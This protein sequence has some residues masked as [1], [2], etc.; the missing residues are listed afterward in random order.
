MAL[1]PLLE[2][3]RPAR[4]LIDRAAAWLIANKVLLP[5]VT[6]IERLVGRIRDRARTRLWRHLV[7][8]LSDD[9]R[10]R[11][12]GLF[13]DGDTSTF[14]ALDSLRTV[15]SKRMPTELYRHLDRL[16]AV[17]A[18]NLRPSPPRG[19]PAATLERLARVARV[20]KPSAIAALQEPRR[21]A[22]VA[23]LFHTLEAAAQDDAVELAEALL[24]DLVGAGE[25]R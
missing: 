16:D 22:T 25:P 9:Q 18:F 3:R 6:V 15:P 13:D 20:G 4:P 23:A 11:I 24:A 1:R 21:T 8:S 19:V 14:A 17:R 10:G 5:G 2:R 7:A 12:A